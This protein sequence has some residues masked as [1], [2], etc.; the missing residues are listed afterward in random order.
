MIRLPRSRAGIFAS[1]CEIL[2]SFQLTAEMHGSTNGSAFL[3]H[4]SQTLDSPAVDAEIAVSQPR[5]RAH[6][7]DILR[8]PEV[9]LQIIDEA[10]ESAAAF[11]V[12]VIF[13]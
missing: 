6:R 5:R 10:E 1:S 4:A 7:N 2:R 12:K 13:R 11:G 3:Q 9:Q 8:G